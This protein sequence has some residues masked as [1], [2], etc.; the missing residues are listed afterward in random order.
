[1][2]IG[3]T[4]TRNGMTEK[5]L[6]AFRTYISDRTITE[7]HHG[8]CIGADNQVHL[9]I[10]RMVPKIKIFI[11]PPINSLYRAFLSG[12]KIYPAKNYLERNKDIVS[13]TEFLIAAPKEYR[14]KVRSG[15]WST[16][17][18]AKQYLRIVI[19][20]YP[21]GILERYQTRI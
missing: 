11:H 20:I 3:F 1:M 6:E 14:E 16:I 17:R 9:I 18:Y 5:Q 7:F 13:E 10:E 8:D 4:G 2:K 15:T 21:D 12:F 19:I